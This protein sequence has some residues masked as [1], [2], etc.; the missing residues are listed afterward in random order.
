MKSV[1]HPV[2]NG[3]TRE[4]DGTKVT[5]GWTKAEEE[6]E[7]APAA[8]VEAAVP[9]AQGLAQVPMGPVM[10]SEA[11]VRLILKDAD[12]SIGKIIVKRKGEK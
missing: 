4:V 11:P 7:V 2:V 3:V 1:N 10:A 5:E 9:V 12:I 8:I 6:K